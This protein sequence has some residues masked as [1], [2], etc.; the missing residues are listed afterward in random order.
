MTQNGS[1]RDINL[2]EPVVHGYKFEN[3]FNDDREIPLANQVISAYHFT[4]DEDFAGVT[5]RDS[6]T[7]IQEAILTEHLDSLITYKV[8]N[9]LL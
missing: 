5:I 7:G 2:I 9:H 8:A 1:S 4:E 3:M 6:N